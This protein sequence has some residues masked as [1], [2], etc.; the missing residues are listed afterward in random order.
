[1]LRQQA[2]SAVSPDLEI[3]IDVCRLNMPIALI[4]RQ[5]ALKKRRVLCWLGRPNLLAYM[6]D[7]LPQTA[8][9]LQAITFAASDK[10]LTIIGSSF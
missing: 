10:A 3:A 4:V 9:P 7:C 2:Y 1:L 8:F 5:G 6:A